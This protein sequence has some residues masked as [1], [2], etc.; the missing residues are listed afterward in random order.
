MPSHVFRRVLVAIAAA[1]FMLAFAG[2][3]SAA[4]YVVL[5]KAKGVPADG[6]AVI[7][8]AGGTVVASYAQIGVII[9][10]SSLSSFRATLMKDSRIEGVSSTARFASQFPDVESASS[11]SEGDLPNAPATDADTFSGLQWDMRQIQAPEAHAITGGSPSV[12][13]GDLDTGLDKDHPDLIP[14]IDFANSVSCV[15]GAPDQSPAAWDDDNGHGT[16]TAGTIA[17]AANGVGI[18]GVAPN[19]KIAGVKVGDTAGFFFPE[20]IVCGF[21]WAGTHRFDVTNNSYFADPFLFNCHNDP[22]QQAIW[23]AESRAIAYAQSQGVTVVAA[24]GNFSDDLAH[25]TQDILS[26]DTGPGETRTIHNNCVVIPTEVAGVIGVTAT[27]VLRQKSFYS[28]YGVSVTEVAAPGGDSILQRNAEAVNGRV[29]STYPAEQP[30]TRRLED[31]TTT[32]TSVYCY[33]QGTSMASPHVAGLAA[34]VISRYG[35]SSSPQNGKLRPGRVAAIIQQ[36]ADPQPCP[37]DATLA[38]YAPF[39]SFSN[40]AAQTCQG[41]TGYNSWYGKGI[42]N[43]LSAITPNP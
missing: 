26:P 17:A 12:L 34:L 40:G 4:K 10:D 43:A 35:D 42:I 16:H 29:L 30:C 2:V 19:V 32:P 18:V 11:G 3:A 37:D 23:K 22:V 20:A 25:P 9:A 38:L 1:S 7:R 41:G 8:N 6:G 31:P 24:E 14:N 28:N 15:G 39:P 33:L 21:M 36:T 27:G 13:V 5:Y